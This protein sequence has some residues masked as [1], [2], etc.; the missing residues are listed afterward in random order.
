[1][2]EGVHAGPIV[3][4]NRAFSWGMGL[5]CPVES[6]SLQDVSWSLDNAGAEW[7]LC[8]YIDGLAD[9]VPI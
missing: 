1:M 8:V 5:D 7:G 3:S 2:S 9:Q 4:Q 6:T